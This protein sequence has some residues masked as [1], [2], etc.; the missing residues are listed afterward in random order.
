MIL[1]DTVHQTIPISGRCEIMKLR[2]LSVQ[3]YMQ[4]SIYRV[5]VRAAVGSR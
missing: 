1:L 4:A 5:H 2:K 3:I